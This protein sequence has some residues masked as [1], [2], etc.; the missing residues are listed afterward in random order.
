MKLNKKEC[1]KYASP[2]LTMPPDHG[3]L[4]APQ[5]D[6]IV[7]TEVKVIDHHRTLI[8]FV[9]PRAQAAQGDFHPLWT[10][11]HTRDDYITLARNPDGTTKWRT[12]AF[13]RLDSDYYFVSKCAFYSAT[14]QEGV[15]RY[16]GNGGSGFHAL[17]RAQN[18]ILQRCLQK[19]ERQRDQIIRARMKGLPALPRDLAAWAHQNAIPAHF[20]YHHA[21]GGKASGICTSCGCEA[22]LTG[23]KHNAKGVCPHCGRELTM[24]SGGRIG[25]LL[26][27]ETCQVIQRTKA[28]ELVVRIIKAHCSYGGDRPGTLVYENARQFIYVGQDGTVQCDRYYYSYS[29]SKWK[30]GDRPEMFPYQYYFESDTCGHVYCRNLA[31]A[32]MG[33]PWQYCPVQAYYEHFHEPMQM[34][35]FLAAHLKHSKLEHLVK[36]GF[37]NL[38]CDLAYRGNY[39]QTL[40]EAQNRTHRLL[41]VGAEDVAFLQSLDVNTSALKIFQ[42]YC[43]RNLKDRQQLLMWQLE[44]KIERGVDP[45]LEHM[46]AHKFMRYLD[47]Q[48]AFLQFRLTQYK[49]QRYRSMQ[50]LVT[51]YRDYLDMCE[52]QR[53]DMTNS[54]V[55]F[56]RDLQKAHDKL[57]HQIQLKADAKLRREFKASYQRVMG[58]LD[59]EFNG[60]KIVCP[61]TPEDIIAEGNAL[62][63]CVGGYVDRVAQQK[64][65]ILFLR[66]C[67]NLSK[68]FYTVEVCHQRAVQVRGMQNADMTPEVKRFMN[69]WERQVLQGQEFEAA[70]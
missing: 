32:L 35:P 57:T 18:K 37:Y 8:L 52:Q 62:H 10:V 12:A 64:T 48:Y 38:A 15:E 4:Y 54:F 66:R 11:F 19:R 67:E 60:M 55:L 42:G 70:A 69:R 61:A 68:P 36:V 58:Q 59:F 39:D 43:Q 2:E 21:R 29:E 28:G 53:C 45:A 22:V 41:G 49:A 20:F 13:E 26:D 56:P 14:D 40:D 3:L 65:M 50:D 30:C 31:R 17:V 63:H 23:V 33:T 25:R 46:T 27:R 34:Y 47:E 9:Y 5:V 1:R 24:K 7:H 16:C 6:Y 44:R 51:E